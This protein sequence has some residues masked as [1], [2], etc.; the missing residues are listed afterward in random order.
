[1]Q[2]EEKVKALGLS[3]NPPDCV[4]MDAKERDCIERGD[5]TPCEA[6]GLY[7]D[8]CNDN[9]EESDDAVIADALRLRWEYSLRVRVESAYPLETWYGSPYPL[10]PEEKEQA[11][12]DTLVTAFVNAAHELRA[13]YRYTRRE[14]AE[15]IP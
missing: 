11:K 2:F 5:K 13:K 3:M 10:T 1:M 15:M 7:R 4:L 14:L 9:P 12:Q 6:C 8:V